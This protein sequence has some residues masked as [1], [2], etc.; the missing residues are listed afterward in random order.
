M[1]IRVNRDVLYFGRGI[2]KIFSNSSHLETDLESSLNTQKNQNRE[3]PCLF[4]KKASFTVE[5]AFCGTAFFLAIFSLLFLFRILEGYEKNIL[6]LDTAVKEYECFGTK[7]TTG[8]GFL[9][10]KMIL[11]EEK[12]KVCYLKGKKE[13]PFIGSKLFSISLYQQLCFSE[14]EGKSMVP[15]KEATGEYVYLAENGTVYHKNSACVYLNPAISQVLYQDIDKKR[16]RSFGKYTK[17][18]RCGNHKKN[19]VYVFITSYGDSWHTLK[20]CSGLK[21]TVRRVPLSGIGNLPACSKCGSG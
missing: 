5:A 19:P 18:K 8:K 7:I 17:C 3:Y 6:Q 12:N 9:E 1:V 21:R 15:A 16:N 4:L 14:Y 20:T 2:K 11:W 13:I 10:G